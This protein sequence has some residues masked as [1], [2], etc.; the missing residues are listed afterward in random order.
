MYYIC[1]GSTQHH[2]ELRGGVCTLRTTFKYRLSKSIWN[3]VFVNI[4]IFLCSVASSQLKVIGRPAQMNTFRLAV[5]PSFAFYAS[6]LFYIEIHLLSSGRALGWFSFIGWLTFCSIFY[7]LLFIRN[8][9]FS[10]SH[11]FCIKKHQIYHHTWACN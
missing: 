4:Y 1:I 3:T 5:N 10:F 11:G 7:L 6:H 2:S 9:M 8:V